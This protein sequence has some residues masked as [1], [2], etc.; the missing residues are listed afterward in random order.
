[1]VAEKADDHSL[2]HKYLINLCCTQLNCG[3]SL[4]VMNEWKTDSQFGEGE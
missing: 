1:M 3:L 2:I 4:N